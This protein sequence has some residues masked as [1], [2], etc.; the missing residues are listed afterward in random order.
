MTRTLLIIILLVGVF[1]VAFA[2]AALL[3]QA[4]PSDGSVALTGLSG[5]LWDG[6]AE[7]LLGGRSAGRLAWEIQP[8]TILQGAL[9]YHLALSGPDRA[10]A[11]E[12]ALRPR[13]FELTLDGT[14][15]AAWINE[16]VGQYDIRLSGEFAFESLRLEAPYTLIGSAE[17]AAA[18]GT[19]AGRLTW[20]GGPVAYRLTGQ[21]FAGSLPP[22]E[23]R[24]GEALETVVFTVGNPTPLLRAQLLANGFARVGMTRLLPKLLNNPWPGTGPDHEVVLEVEEQVL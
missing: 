19:A 20:S 17:P 15:G 16:W 24:F 1:T 3:R 4:L 13:A 10:L 22:L 8:V 5:T 23:A 7:L 6:D 14:A 12:V 18:P 21:D 11:A 9:G 2:P